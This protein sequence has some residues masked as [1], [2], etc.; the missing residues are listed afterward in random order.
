MTATQQIL[1]QIPGNPWN[2]LQ[3]VDR[4]WQG[5]RDNSQPV[6]LTVRRHS[7]LLGEVEWDVVI[8][9]GTLGILLGAALARQKWRVVLVERGILK[10]RTQEWN[11]SR[12]ELRTFVELGLLTEDELER[13]I[14]SEYNPGRVSFR[15]GSD[16]WVD[17]I[18]NIGVD[19]VYLLETLKQK[20]LQAGG[21][22][23]ENTNFKDAVVH[24]DGV[25]TNTD[26]H[27]LSARLLVDA[28]GHFSP[29]SR[30]AR[31][32]RKPDAV[33][34][35]VGTCA[36]GYAANETGDLLVSFT[37]I[38]NQCQYFWEAFPARDGRTT[39]LFTYLDAHPDRFSLPFFFDEYL[40]LLPKYQSIELEALTFKRALFGVFPSYRDSPLKS[41][42]PRVLPVGDSSG[43]QS[44]LSF[45]GFGA[46]VR[47][48]ARLSD[49]VNE[50]LQADCLDRSALQLLQPYQPN[51]SVTWLFQQ[52]MSLDADAPVRDSEAINRLL[53]AVFSAMERAG[54]EVL[55]PF[56]QDVVRFGSLSQALFRTSISAPLTVTKIVPQLGV[57]PLVDWTGHYVQL[58]AYSLL[59]KLEPSL[60]ALSQLASPQQQYTLKRWL[61]AWQYGSGGDFTAKRED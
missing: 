12:H 41:P 52:A 23:L 9:G 32:Q 10:G 21:T 60:G 57:S 22:L 58:G 33:C 2:G 17:D 4:I 11:I 8:C 18:L 54:D 31:G 59:S 40:R 55:R 15:G 24:P 36:D 5:M 48:L 14:A 1:T 56:L 16:I 19:P 47:H 50:A 37:P 51:L 49:G 43:N 39:Y 53:V 28:M 7:Q 46:M 29:I 13:S 3:N 6:P 27:H 25:C 20:F 26:E 42:W 61:Q 44:P 38:L 30:Q 35:V 45:G 34:M